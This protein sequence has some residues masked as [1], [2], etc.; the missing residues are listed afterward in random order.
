MLHASVV[1]HNDPIRLLT[2]LFVA[3]LAM[4]TALAQPESA[5]EPV[6]PKPYD[7]SWTYTFDPTLNCDP[8]PNAGPNP[9]EIGLPAALEAAERRELTLGGLSATLEWAERAPDPTYRASLR[10]LIEEYRCATSDVQRALHAL[11]AAGEPSETFV[12]YA[13]DW[14]RDDQLAI[15]AMNTLA[16]RGTRR[17]LPRYAR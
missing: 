1:T 17:S 5:F 14:R 15:R 2:A 11:E 6:R 4:N 16:V 7:R 12:R 8:G 13:Q 3:A 10:R 9:Y